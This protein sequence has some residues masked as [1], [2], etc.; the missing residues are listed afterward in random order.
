MTS[1]P[2]LSLPLPTRARSASLAAAVVAEAARRLP[3]PRAGTS[4]SLATTTSAVG[5]RCGR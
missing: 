4:S 2:D 5:S 3:S 1:H